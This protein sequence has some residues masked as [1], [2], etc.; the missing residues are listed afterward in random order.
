MQE[1]KWNCNCQF[2]VGVRVRCDHAHRGH[3]CDTLPCR[4]TIVI[5]DAA[6]TLPLRDRYYY[7]NY[8]LP[9]YRAEVQF[10]D[11]KRPKTVLQLYSQLQ[12]HR[13]YVLV[14]PWKQEQSGF[15][16]HP[17]FFHP[18]LNSYCSYCYSYYSW[19]PLSDVD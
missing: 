17:I 4:T 11:W 12:L 2:L 3:N 15:A 18:F 6:I 5:L 7:L 19:K 9:V 1:K 13:K 14:M 10:E 8:Y 16:I